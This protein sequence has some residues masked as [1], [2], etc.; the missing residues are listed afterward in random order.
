MAG[1]LPPGAS[2]QSDEVGV[3]RVA[4][5]DV[6][7]RVAVDVQ[8]GVVSLT[9]Q[10]GRDG[11]VVG[12]VLLGR[13]AGERDRDRRGGAAGVQDGA[14]EARDAAE[15]REAR[16]LA[17]P[18]LAEERA[19]LQQQ[20]AERAGV[21]PA[22]VEQRERAEARAEPGVGRG[23]GELGEGGGERA[24]V[25]GR[26][27]VVLVAVGGVEQRDA[28]GRDPVRRDRVGDQAGQ[29]GEVLVLRAVVR[30]EQRER[31]ARLGVRRRPE[32]RV[33]GDLDRRARVGRREPGGRPVAR[34]LDDGLVAERPRRPVRVLR[35]AAPSRRRPRSG[36]P[37]GRSGGGGTRPPRRRRGAAAAARCAGARS[38]AA[39]GRRRSRGPR[40]GRS[41]DP[42]APPGRSSRRTIAAAARPSVAGRLV[43]AR[44]C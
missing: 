35:V 33:L 23:G 5:A 26:R 30:D 19:G 6:V 27:G 24:G 4:P 15:A 38:P 25:A 2:E 3:E 41:R 34:E 37:S 43:A 14:D 18:A 42:H 11:A 12:E 20:R 39:A 7:V 44:E 40:A 28:A 17:V 8:R 22:G 10:R 16:L 9:A 21:Q 31:A 29:L 13:A 1:T 32:P 36:T